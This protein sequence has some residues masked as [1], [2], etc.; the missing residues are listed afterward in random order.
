MIDLYCWPTPNGWKISIML[1]ECGLPYKFMP[2]NIG[3][4][5]Q[6]APAFLAISPNNRMPAIVDH[7]P[8]VAARRWRCLRV[9]RFC[10]T[11][12]KKRG[13]FCPPICAAAIR[14]CSG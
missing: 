10:S 11:W 4:G 14:C 8:L 5:E 3:K 12:L 7:A 2:V 6:F 9:A 1:E 13:A